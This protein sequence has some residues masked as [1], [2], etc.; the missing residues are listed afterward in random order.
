MIEKRAVSP[1]LIVALER[2]KKL[3]LIAN[4]ILELTF[5]ARLKYSDDPAD[6][7]RIFEQTEKINRAIG[8]L[9]KIVAKERLE[10]EGLL[11]SMLATII[12]SG[13][14]SGMRKIAELVQGSD[15]SLG[16]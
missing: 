1:E 11:A 3:S 14:S 4:V 2:D 13:S 10:E 9:I 7:T 5:L 6:G 15:G 8:Y 16:A 12:D